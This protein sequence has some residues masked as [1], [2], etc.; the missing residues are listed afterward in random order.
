MPEI[1]VHTE[2]MYA[3]N[4]KYIKIHVCTKKCMPAQKNVCLHKKMYTHMSAQK[5]CMPAHKKMYTHM[6]A[7]KK[8][9]PAQN[10]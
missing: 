7:Q 5:K 6:P 9:M 4:K 2:K 10:E 1:H 3:C 8:C